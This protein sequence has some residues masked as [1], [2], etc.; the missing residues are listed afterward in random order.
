MTLNNP[1]TYIRGVITLGGTA[2]DPVGVTST[3]FEYR[4]GAGAWNIICT[5]ATAL[6]TCPGVDSRLVPDG[7]YDLRMTATDTLGHTS[8]SPPVTVQVDNTAPNRTAIQGA[9]GGT[10]GQMDANDTVTFSWSEP[11]LASSIMA[12]WA[13][14][15]TPIR[16]RVTSN[17]G[18]NDALEVFNAAGTLELDLAQSVALNADYVSATTWFNRHDAAR[19]RQHRCRHARHAHLGHDPHR[20]HHAGQHDLGRPPRVR[21]TSPATPPR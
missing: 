9:N 12:G 17:G 11:M 14:T 3:N 8:A 15:S 21:L 20:R 5:D 2:T 1:G 10:L 19:A 4:I 13:G 18:S 16:V 7:S 6:Y